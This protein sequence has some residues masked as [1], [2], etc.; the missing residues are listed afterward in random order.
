MR[1]EFDAAVNSIQIASLLVGTVLPILVGLVTT[2]VTSS[3]TKAI[4]LAALSAVSGFLTELIDVTQRGDVFQVD[5]ALLT[6]MMTFVVA[7]AIHYGFW[8]PTG[9]T[10][11][12]L[13]TGH[14]STGTRKQGGWA[15]VHTLAAVVVVAL[16]VIGLV[17]LLR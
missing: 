4:L 7:V 2:K 8:K 6:W 15:G 11:K 10:E 13:T 16:A 14:T 1:V 17:A 12:A 3:R 9:V 5:Q